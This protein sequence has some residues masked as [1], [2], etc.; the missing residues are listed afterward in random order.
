M[1]KSRLLRVC[2]TAL[3]LG[4]TS[5]VV[6]SSEPYV[7]DTIRVCA[8][9][10][11]SSTGGRSSG[12]YFGGSAT[13]FTSEAYEYVEM[14]SCSELEAAVDGCDIRNPPLL[15]VDG[16]GSG[17]TA[18]IVPDYLWVNGLPATSLGPIFT[19]ACNMHDRCYGT[20]GRDKD[21][22][23]LQLYNDMIAYAQTSIS[24]AQWGYYA[25]HVKNQAELF[26]SSLHDGIASGAS[27]NAYLNAQGQ[28]L[29]RNAHDVA[30]SLGCI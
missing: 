13:D 1:E 19:E 29:C 8:Y 28:G 3:V 27:K 11:S 15:A 9:C 14:P 26:A 4:T 5:A 10:G 2:I 22:C 16:C 18:G 30:K 6:K 12:S 23:D 24:A 21:Q 7:L 25:P 17:W 20:Y